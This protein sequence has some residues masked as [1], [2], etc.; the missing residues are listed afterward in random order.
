M[1]GEDESKQMHMQKNMTE[2]SCCVKGVYGLA[3]GKGQGPKPD[4][5]RVMAGKHVEAL[6]EEV[7]AARQFSETTLVIGCKKTE[8]S[9]R[10]AR[11]CR[12][13]RQ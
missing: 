6:L 9:T 11:P 3:A 5:G 13:R 10:I 4:I 2:H 8:A 1:G 12:C 7:V